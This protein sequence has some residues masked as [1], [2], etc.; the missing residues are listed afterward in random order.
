M[1]VAVNLFSYFIDNATEILAK[2]EKHLFSSRHD[3]L[4]T[5][6]EIDKLW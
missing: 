2:I 5:I 3:M 6:H 1:N 4:N